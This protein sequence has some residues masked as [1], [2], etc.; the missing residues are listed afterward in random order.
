MFQFWATHGGKMGVAALWAHKG[1]GRLKLTNKSFYWVYLLGQ[2][3]SEIK[4]LKFY[5]L[6]YNHFKIIWIKLI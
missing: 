2:P 1:M 4:F 3:L 6:H 5:T